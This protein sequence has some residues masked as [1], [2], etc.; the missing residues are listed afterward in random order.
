[1]LT[2]RFGGFLPRSA[3]CHALWA[4][5]PSHWGPQ[6]PPSIPTSS[7]H[8][9]PR[10]HLPSQPQQS[11]GAPGAALEPRIGAEDGRGAQPSPTAAAG[12]QRGSS[13]EGQ[14]AALGA[15]RGRNGAE[16]N[17]EGDSP[18]PKSAG[19][20]RSRQGAAKAQLGP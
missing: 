4:P 11:C 3:R 14:N 9:P 12:E 10:L 16:A 2:P 19:A 5:L 17:L 13:S 6:I 20:A 7:S 8:P 15:A 18:P 1:M